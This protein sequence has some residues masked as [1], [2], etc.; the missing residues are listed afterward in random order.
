[1]GKIRIR[2]LGDESAEK[3]QK[4]QAKKRQDAKKVVKEPEGVP[5]PEEKD[6]KQESGIPSTEAKINLK[7]LHIKKPHP[8]KKDNESKQKRS[9]KYQEVVQLVD[10]R[11]QYPLNEALQ[12]LPK[13][14]LSSFDETVE[15]HVNTKEIGISGNIVLPH[16]T[17]KKIRIAI[18]NDSIIAN[19]EKGLID[20]DVLLAAPMMMPKLAKVT[21]VL[22]PK[23][24]MPNPKNGTITT[25]PEDT[26]KKFEQGQVRYKTE[27]KSPVIHLSVGKLSF[28]E[29]K[30][31]ENI[32]T[33]ITAVQTQNIRNV[34]LKSTMSPAIHISV[35]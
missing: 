10:K 18:A 21:K 6:V 26:A 27:A 16:G 13:L 29:D 9:K 34:T 35:V 20:F 12:L 31:T 33:V 1:M 11:K 32:L 23:G 19:I 3:K 28:G 4:I 22:G 24:L 30:L 2:T 14:K 15:L 8:A 7:Q 17:G 5:T 25:T